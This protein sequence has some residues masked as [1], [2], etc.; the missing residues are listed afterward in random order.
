LCK[1]RRWTYIPGPRIYLATVK[2]AISCQSATLAHW[3][4][5]CNISPIIPEQRAEMGQRALAKV[6]SLGG[7]HQYGEKV[8][9]IFN[10]LSNPLDGAGRT[11]LG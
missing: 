5:D 4:N 11:A 10:S 1:R 6:K 9:S 3:L 8:M 7:W 2:K